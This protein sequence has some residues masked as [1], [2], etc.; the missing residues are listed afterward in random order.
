MFV[1]RHGWIVTRPNELGLSAGGTVSNISVSMLAWIAQFALV[2]LRA[3]TRTEYR[4]ATVK[5]IKSTGDS[6]MSV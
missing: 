5:L 1:V 3:V 2:S 4:C 6:S